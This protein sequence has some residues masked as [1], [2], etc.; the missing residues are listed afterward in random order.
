[1]KSEDG[2]GDDDDGWVGFEVWFV[3]LCSVAST[4]I[5]LGIASASCRASRFVVSEFIGYCA[6]AN[7]LY[8]AI[9][10][11]DLEKQLRHEKHFRYIIT[12]GVAYWSRDFVQ[13]LD[14]ACKI[15]TGAWIWSERTNRKA[16]FLDYD[17]TVVPQLQLLKPH[18]LL[19][20]KVSFQDTA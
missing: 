15:T 4:L 18:P 11:P 1:M 16:I 12:H 14:R 3:W 13:D 20:I 10:M 6:V 5:A 8:L 19:E 17:G 7:A 2:D 9:T